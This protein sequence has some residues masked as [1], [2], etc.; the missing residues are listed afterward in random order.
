MVG[1]R[2]NVYVKH[3][4]QGGTENVEDSGTV[5]DKCTEELRPILY[6]LV[7]VAILRV[8]KGSRYSLEEQIQG[9][10][11]ILRGGIQQQTALTRLTEKKHLNVNID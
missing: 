1:A 4:T 9:V 10:L 7:D 3:E 5:G 11:G 2:S 8:H 6:S